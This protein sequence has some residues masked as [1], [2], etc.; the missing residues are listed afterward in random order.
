V[1]SSDL[2]HLRDKVG[3]IVQ[4]PR[5]PCLALHVGIRHQLVHAAEGGLSQARVAQR[6][7]AAQHAQQ[8]TDAGKGTLLSE[9]QSSRC[10]TALPPL[11]QVS[12]G[13]QLPTCTRHI[14]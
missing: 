7:C 14:S 1:C 3:L 11:A 10:M 2:A 9:T 5:R 6:Q 8:L 4:A 13:P 12:L